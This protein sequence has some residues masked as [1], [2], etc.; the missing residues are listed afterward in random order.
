[1]AANP[2]IGV[3]GV[4]RKV[5][6]QFVGIGGVA[7]KVK[8]GFIGV[9]GVAR[10]FYAGEKTVTVTA[11]GV[12]PSSTGVFLFG[13]TLQKI[14]RVD[15][16]IKIDE[17]NRSIPGT[18]NTFIVP[19]GEE[20]CGG[21]DEFNPMLVVGGFNGGESISV[22]HAFMYYDGEVVRGVKLYVTV[23]RDRVEAHF[24]VTYYDDYYGTTTVDVPLTGTTD[25]S[26][27]FVCESD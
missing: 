25:Y 13:Q 11:S 14:K 6:G 4:A 7:R 2:Y 24:E 21:D 22:S 12:L 26:F 1:M 16:W 17:M 23:Y 9:G 10:K 3:G 18:G 19:W 27:T 20:A 15:G 5:K 8:Q